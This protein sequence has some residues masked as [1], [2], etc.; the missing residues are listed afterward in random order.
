MRLIRIRA[1]VPDF[2]LIFLRSRLA[3]RQEAMANH[4]QIL[5]A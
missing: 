3:E 1:I 2:F 4:P 5:T